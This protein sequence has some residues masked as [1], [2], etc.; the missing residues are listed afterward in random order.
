MLQEA[1]VLINSQLKQKRKTYSTSEN[2]LEMIMP[3]SRNYSYALSIFLHLILLVMMYLIKINFDYPLSDYVELGF[4]SR[5]NFSSSGSIG[6]R[7]DAIEDNTLSSQSKESSEINPNTEDINLPKTKHDFEDN[8][9]VN[10]DKKDN[11]TETGNKSNESDSKTDSK[12]NKTTGEGSFG[13]EIDWGGKGKRKI[14]SYIIPQY[15][16]GVQKEIDIRL[17]FSILPDGSVGMIFPVTKADTKL[18]NAAINALR[19]WKFEPLS[20]AQQ[21]AE[22]QALIVFP[23]RL[24]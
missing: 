2:L 19:Q 15:P 3:D 9:A 22:Q 21:Q 12:G 14:Y 4:G 1:L 5:G 11:K 7:I 6:D 18:E 13:Y 24:Q 20:A 10:K 17:R 8:I 23:Y 16:S